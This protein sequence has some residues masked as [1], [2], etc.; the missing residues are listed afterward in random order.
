VDFATKPQ[1][2][3]AMFARAFAAGVPGAWVTGDEVYG[4]AGPLR[5]W[6]EAQERA[7]VLA[8]SCDHMVRSDG[9]QQRVDALVAALP[10]GAWQRLSAGEGS[11]GPRLYDWAWVPVATAGTPGWAQWV[12]ARRSLSDPAEVAYYRAY[13]PTQTGLPTVVQVAGLRWAVEEGFER[14]KDAVGLDQ[15]E[16]R[17][18]QAWYRHITLALL[19]HAY[20]EVTRAHAT[21]A[22]AQDGGKKGAKVLPA[23]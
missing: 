1:L 7:Y 3:Q 17:R 19:T 8:V 15:Y 13:G 6:L 9:Q 12:L 22:A 21:A 18:W 5:P 16:V 2:A 11:Q 10:A 4:N 14:A 20:L 23:T